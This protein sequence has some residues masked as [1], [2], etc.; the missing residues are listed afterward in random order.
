[1]VEQSEESSIDTSCKKIA[2]MEPALFVS[3]FPASL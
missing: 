1:M 2:K 3:A